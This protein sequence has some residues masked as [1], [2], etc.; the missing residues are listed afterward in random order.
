MF[1]STYSTRSANNRLV[2]NSSYQMEEKN[3]GKNW[4]ESWSDLEKR[5]AAREKKNRKQNRTVKFCIC[6]GLLKRIKSPKKIRMHYP[7]SKKC[8]YMPEMDLRA[9]CAE[10]WPYPFSDF[11]FLGFVTICLVYLS[12]Q[13]NTISIFFVAPTSTDNWPNSIQSI[14]ANSEASPFWMSAKQCW[15]GKRSLASA[16]CSCSWAFHVNDVKNRWNC[17]KT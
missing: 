11:G 12:R 9:I 6:V 2:C 15:S 1:N 10:K 14:E 4:C 5:K 16:R 8:Y 7:I 3:A 13:K 17:Y